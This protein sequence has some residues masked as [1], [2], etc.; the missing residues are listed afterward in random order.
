[1]LTTKKS[2]PGGKYNVLNDYRS[3]TPVFTLACLGRDSLKNPASFRKSSLDYVILKSGGK[4]KGFNES[5]AK[6]TV[7]VDSKSNNQLDAKE[8][9]AGFNKE[10]PGRFDMYIDN[11]DME[12]IIAPGE[13]NGSSV[14]TQI[15]FEVFEP[16]SL[17][18]FI[19]ALHVAAVS[20][21]FD[22]YVQASYLLKLEFWGYPDDQDLAKPEIIP[23][24]SRYF[25]FNFT[26]VDI[27]VTEN[28]TRYTCQGVP[29]ADMALSEPDKILAD[30]KMTGSTVESVLSNFFASYNKSLDER[31]IKEKGTDKVKNHDTYEIVFPEA[32]GPKEKLDTSGKSVNKI[33]KAEMPSFLT[34]NAVLK[35]V[36]LEKKAD[37]SKK[38][39]KGASSDEAAP[40]P[41]SQ[42][43][44][45][46]PNAGVVQ[47]SQGSKISDIITAVI[48]DSTYLEKILKD[49]KGSV[50]EQ[51][52]I[53]YFMI[54]VNVFPKEEND[55]ISGQPLY[56]YQFVVIPYK[57]HF[58]KLPLQKGVSWDP[59]D[60]MPSVKRIY[61]YIYTGKNVDVTN[62][63]LTFNNLFF[64][65][66]PPKA[67]NE[68]N[69]E[70]ATSAGMNNTPAATVP[71]ASTGGTKKEVIPTPPVRATNSSD[72]SDSNARGQR[73]GAPRTDPYYKFAEYAHNAILESVDQCTAEIEIIGDPYYLVLGGIGN[74]VPTVE[75][76]GLTTDG[77]AD[78]QS[79]QVL[80]RINF[81][82]PDD[83]DPVTGF[84]RFNKSLVPY[85]GIYQVIEVK[86]MLKEGV[87]KQQ[88][89]L[90]R[91]PGQIINEKQP[92]EDPVEIVARPK[93][94][95][96]TVADTAPATVDKAGVRP[97]SFDLTSL[98]GRGLPSLGLP[99]NL[100]D[101]TVSGVFK[102]GANILSQASGIVSAVATGAGIAAQLGVPVGKGIGGLNALT[103]GLRTNAITSNGISN[104]LS[105]TG[106]LV[107]QAGQILG[108]NSASGQTLASDV[109]AQATSQVTKLANATLSGTGSPAEVS[110]LATLASDTG[111]GAMSALK[112]LGSGA[113]DV[114]GGIGD[115][116]K[117]LTSGLPS[118][119]L[120]TASKFGINPS[121]LAGLDP[122]LQSKVTEQLSNLGKDIPSDVDMTA[123]TKTGVSL[124]NIAVDNLPNIPA[125]AKELV[126]EAPELPDLKATAAGVWNR[127][128]SATAAGG[129]ANPTAIA[130]KIGSAQSLLGQAT[131]VAGSIEGNLGKMTDL[132][133]GSALG[134]FS[135]GSIS[136]L[137]KSV[138]GKFGS[139]SAGSSSPLDKLVNGL[140][141]P[142]AAPYTGTDPIVRARL[143]LP[144]IEEA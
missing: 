101:F 39:N 46:E 126:A 130:G 119:P 118:D 110:K 10:S 141:S 20:A 65:A 44:K 63:K 91:M 14:A 131:G 38:D 82:N 132:T 47:F 22:S 76:S 31:A 120:A 142:N 70:Q 26:S 7:S 90:I 112:K 73:A 72:G 121:Q 18:G 102:S 25:V 107:S 86:S 55:S 57:V 9:V 135:V 21:G 35:M 106:A 115:K 138:T 77:T 137:S 79:G 84:V 27:T 66:I 114:V 98:L 56:K 144:P 62:F 95:A 36:P 13:R 50:D 64:Q 3:Y 96:Q 123:L 53:E 11:I 113:A 49:V 134:G 34:N 105:G 67:G 43:M 85:S 23:N 24:S 109:S 28:G 17:N 133:G 32:P 78:H 4:D 143:G 2:I 41:Q 128:K 45:Y 122:K 92:A 69:V 5:A 8:L 89:K 40:T 83:I 61:N 87:F 125:T 80:V 97:S 71:N 103:Q 99:G 37:T 129:L 100:S 58:S 94:F 60:L 30:V 74:Q 19:E 51:G 6:G 127:V 16:L 33:A 29:S 12:C 117:S 15:R 68:Q 81:A 124:K 111:A 136:D 116:V 88:L 1:M 93:P 52:N 140:G 59:N 139:V 104:V 75:E 42:G 54:Q 48:R 108:G